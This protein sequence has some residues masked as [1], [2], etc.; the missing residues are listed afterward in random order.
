ML[1]CG[2]VGAT[3]TRLALFHRG[4]PLEPVGF[5][6]F[7]SRTAGGL[8]ALVRAYRATAPAPIEAA[9]FAIA[10]PVLDGRATTTNLPWVVSAAD[11]AAE[12]EGAPVH[13]LN[14]LEALAWAVSLLPPHLLVD[15]IPGRA[16][17][18]A[19]VAVI[20]AGT[21]LGEAGLLFDGQRRV[22]VASEGGHADFAPRSEREIALLRFLLRRFPHVSYERLLSGAGLVHLLEFLRD[23]EMLPVPPA[24]A[25]ALAAGDGAAAITQAGLTGTA[26][27]ATAALDLFVAIYGAE[28]GNL[29]L[30]LM[31]LGG[32]YVGGG[33][34]P[35][36]LA[37][38]RDGGFR[39][40]FLAKGRFRALLTDVPVRI[41]ID[42]RAGLFG[43]AQH[44]ET[45]GIGG[46]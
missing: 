37:K 45:H 11:L 14:D 4:R 39:E 6:A 46:G 44:A 26:P 42:D 21:G 40:A 2:D 23:V 25:A 31:A 43:A 30:K 17:E 1:L 34:A 27:I 10:G 19:S 29:A 15:V 16:V 28:A 41:V 13:L 33:I 35:R 32:V 20:A 5:A 36:I 24:L 8:P 22:P 9:C 18:T 3:T 38:L 12:V 7:P